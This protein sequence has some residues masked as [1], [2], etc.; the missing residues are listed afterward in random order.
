LY[1]CDYSQPKSFGKASVQDQ[2]SACGA[3]LYSVRPLDLDV[4]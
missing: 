1:S 4:A 3:S 2:A